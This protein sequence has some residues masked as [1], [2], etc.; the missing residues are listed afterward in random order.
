MV[1]DLVGEPSPG[2][3]FQR[4]VPLPP[5]NESLKFPLQELAFLLTFVG[6]IPIVV[7]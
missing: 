6:D 1:P 4:Y 7:G 2:V 5:P 3:K